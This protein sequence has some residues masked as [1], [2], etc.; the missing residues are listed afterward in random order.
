M[1]IGSGRLLNS[2]AIHTRGTDQVVL[3]TNLRYAAVHQFGSKDRG[4]IGLG[5]RTEE[6]QNT[7]VKVK[8]HAYFQLSPSLGSGRLKTVDKL[9]R[10]RKVRAIIAGPRNQRRV[11]VAGHA[12]HQ[13]IPA[14]PYLVFRPEDP[15][16]LADV[17]KAYVNSVRRNAGL[18]E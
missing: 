2:I 3:G 11:N 4:S 6:Q 9:G 13:N 7:T 10:S 17:A 14:R 12:R 16:R 1:L 15:E 18:G 8:E 5:P